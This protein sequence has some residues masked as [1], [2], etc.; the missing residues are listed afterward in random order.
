MPRTTPP[1]ADI[2][3]RR[4]AFFLDVDGTIA[5]IVPNPEDARVSADDVAI[6]DQLHSA[7]NGA[8]ALISGRD[9][10]QL[11]RIVDP[12]RLPA[13]GVHGL[14]WRLSGSAITRLDFDAQAH[15]ELVERIDRFATERRG[16]HCEPKPGSVALHF[17]NRPDLADS[18]RQF[19]QHLVQ[20]DGRLALLDGKM[21]YEL[22]FGG[23][24]KGDA[25]TRLIAQPPFAGRLAFFAGDDVTD[26]AAF[27]SV[28]RLGGITV[29]IGTGPS[30]ARHRL[31]DPAALMA[32]LRCLL[33]APDDRIE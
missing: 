15:A 2:S 4:T 30:H 29:K 10:A 18:C 26:E 12:L 11:D 27:R 3:L 17:R 16:L 13:V 5:D 32:Y 1:P 23:Q 20:R 6:L 31:P 25:V 19:M 33:D 14:E 8:V 22:I 7:S 21:V 28:N 9:I 24:T